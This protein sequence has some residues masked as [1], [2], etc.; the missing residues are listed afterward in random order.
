MQNL[1]FGADYTPA[2]NFNSVITIISFVMTFAYT[3]GIPILYYKVLKDDCTEAELKAV[4]DKYGIL[5]EGLDLERWGKKVIVFVIVG[6]LTKKILI[7]ATV[8]FLVR[9]PVI[10]VMILVTIMLLDT[11]FYLHFRPFTEFW[12]NV[13]VVFNQMVLLLIAYH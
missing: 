12:D 1:R 5:A 10:T 3:I 6:Q 9:Q 11:C 13:K 7:A 2:E 4:M 8:V